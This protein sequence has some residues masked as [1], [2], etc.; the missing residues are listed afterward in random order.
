MAAVGTELQV[1]PS[2]AQFSAPDPSQQISVGLA[3]DHQ[4]LN[5][6]LAVALV[7]SWEQEHLKQEQQQ[8][9]SNGSS[10]PADTAAARENAAG[11]DAAAAERLQQLQSGVLPQAYCDGLK[12]A[13]WPGRSQVSAVCWAFCCGVHCL[14]LPLVWL[15]GWLAGAALRRPH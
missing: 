6:S 7:S 15:A 5:A 3:G 13:T 10:S 4:L 8:H 9:L 1:A 2:L 12:K 11:R 14:Q